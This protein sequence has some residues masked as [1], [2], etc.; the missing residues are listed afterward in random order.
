MNPFL[1]LLFLQLLL[2]FIRI[3]TILI[4]YYPKS[5]LVPKPKI[6]LNLNLQYSLCHQNS[7]VYPVL[8]GPK[9]DRLSRPNY[10]NYRQRLAS[11]SRWPVDHF[12]FCITLASNGFYHVSNDTDAADNSDREEDLVVCAF[13]SCVKSRWTADEDVQTVHHQLNP[14]C[15]YLRSLARCQV[16]GNYALLYPSSSLSN[17]G[18]VLAKYLNL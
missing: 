9:D 5:F 2:K 4:K 14:E 3:S 6:V 12:L 1:R 8:F 10:E 16:G 15:P 17:Q 18:I 7:L 13:C 11:F